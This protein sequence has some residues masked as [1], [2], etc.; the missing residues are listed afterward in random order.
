MTYNCSTTKHFLHAAIPFIRPSASIT[1][2]QSTVLV[3][4]FAIA[5]LLATKNWNNST[6]TCATRH[7]IGHQHG[8]RGNLRILTHN[9]DAKPHW[10]RAGQKN[11]QLT[12]ICNGNFLQSIGYQWSCFVQHTEGHFSSS[13]SHIDRNIIFSPLPPP[14]RGTVHHSRTLWMN[15]A[16][17][18]LSITMFASQL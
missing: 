17:N 8:R 11:S 16:R 4:I 14:A 9:S 6:F 12:T 7:I 10:P 18:S 13:P 1:A 3:E 2:N 15:V 5:N